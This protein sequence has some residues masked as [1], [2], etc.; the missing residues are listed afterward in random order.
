M[1]KV[2]LF[3]KK[4][5][6]VLFFGFSLLVGYWRWYIL[7]RAQWFIY[8]MPITGII[9]VGITQGKKGIREQLKSAVRIKTKGRYYLGIIGVLLAASLLTLLLAYLIYGDVPNFLFLRTEAHFLPLFL[10]F[11][12]L[13]GPLAEELF[14]LRGYALPLLLKK[15]SPLTSSIIVGTFFGAWHLIEFFRPG[16]SQFA[17]G[18]NFYPLFILL[19]IGLSTMMTWFYIKSDNNLF[20]G[21]IFFHWMMNNISV[22]LLTDITF[23]E[24]NNA[25]PMNSHYFVIN[26]IIVL[27]F[28]TA[29]AL[30]GNMYLKDSCSRGEADK[31]ED[32]L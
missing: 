2:K 14:G 6:I 29:F 11:N 27:I 1:N 8:G 21:G 23:T 4:N 30:K 7:G 13:G 10:L 12:L 20:L 18:L 17:I 9:L 31:A 24:V 19:E 26:A 25:P 28:A 32:L 16:S 5:Q 15:Y 3:I 22:L